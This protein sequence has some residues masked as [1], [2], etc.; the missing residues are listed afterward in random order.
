MFLGE[1]KIQEEVKMISQLPD[2]DDFRGPGLPK[3]GALASVSKRAYGRFRKPSRQE[4]KHLLFN[5]QIR[6]KL[7]TSIREIAMA[8][9]KDGFKQNRTLR[10]VDYIPIS[11]TPEEIEGRILLTMGDRGLSRFTRYFF[12]IFDY[13]IYRQ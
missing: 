6:K 11:K 7:C 9:R 2:Y 1:F 4:V 12:R 5:I 8:D 3:D 13:S 10:R